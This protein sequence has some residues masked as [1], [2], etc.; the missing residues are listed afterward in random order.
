MRAR[1]LGWVVAGAVALGG[2]AVTPAS[3]PVTQNGWQVWSGDHVTVKARCG[4]LPVRLTGSHT[5]VVLTGL[6]RLVQ[7]AGD[8]NDAEIWLAPGGR[9]EI[10][11]A[12]NDV[13]W[14]QTAPGA[15]PQLLSRGTDNSFH[16]EK[17]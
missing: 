17:R 12:H 16:R 3:P 15:P 13:W 14:H 6:C 2:C 11:G 4:A 1:G 9:I 7:L 10:T 5:E 8:H